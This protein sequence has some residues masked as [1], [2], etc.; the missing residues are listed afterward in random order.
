MLPR[1]NEAILPAFRQ[2][3]EDLKGEFMSDRAVLREKLIG[4]LERM[5][6]VFKIP[7]DTQLIR[8]SLYCEAYPKVVE[9]VSV[10]DTW[11]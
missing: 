7:K 9:L 2:E 1:V 4:L 5:V 6:V 10:I 3:F 8:W 11:L